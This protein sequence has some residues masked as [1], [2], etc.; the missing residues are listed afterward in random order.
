MSVSLVG[1]EWQN[2]LQLS[3]WHVWILEINFENTCRGLYSKSFVLFMFI[4]FHAS[5]LNEFMLAVCKFKII[6]KGWRIFFVLFE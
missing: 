6:M 3:S 1:A 5:N 4:L 2:D